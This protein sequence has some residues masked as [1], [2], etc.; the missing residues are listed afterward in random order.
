[1]KIINM[2]IIWKMILLL[3]VQSINFLTIDEMVKKYVLE[4]DKQ[5]CSIK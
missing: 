2:Y 4:D 3:L 5:I 1:M